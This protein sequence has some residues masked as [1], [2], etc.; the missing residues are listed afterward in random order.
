MKNPGQNLAK[1]R[2]KHPKNQPKKKKNWL[3]DPKRVTCAHAKAHQ[4]HTNMLCRNA[5]S[6]RV[7]HG[8]EEE[9]EARRDEKETQKRERETENPHTQERC[10]AQTR[11]QQVA[12]I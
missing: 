4:L 11:E 1:Y 10:I 3:K 2:Q 7:V 8:D 6:K 5:V 9:E 12:A